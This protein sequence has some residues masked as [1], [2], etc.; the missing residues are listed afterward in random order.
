MEIK[1]VKTIPLKGITNLSEHNRR[2]RAKI[3][4]IKKEMIE[5]GLSL[6][7]AKEAVEKRLGIPE[8][9]YNQVRIK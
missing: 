1:K 4:M 3:E 6:S 2:W 8:E 7:E 5:N 9:Y